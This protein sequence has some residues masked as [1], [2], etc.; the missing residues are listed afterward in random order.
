M[1]MNRRTFLIAGVAATAAITIPILKCRSHT[2]LT[3]NPL[4]RPR[5]LANF[6]DAKTIR[7]IGDSYR[8]QVPAE[9]R[10]EKLREILLTDEDG[11]KCDAPNDEAISE[12][13]NKKVNREFKEGKIIVEDGWVVSKTEARQCALYSLEG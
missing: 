13:L 11:K 3:D 12:L 10:L 8:A 6:C 5:V 1:I 4:M 9:D 2:F 7:E